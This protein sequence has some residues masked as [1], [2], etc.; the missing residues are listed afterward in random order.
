MP[1]S[2]SGT[3]LRSPDPPRVLRRI[4]TAWGNRGSAKRLGHVSATPRVARG[5]LLTSGMGEATATR[6]RHAED[7]RLPARWLGASV[8][9]PRTYEEIDSDPHALSQAVFVVLAGSVG[10]G[11][12]VFPAEGWLGVLGGTALGVVIWIVATTLVWAIGVHA[13]GH[14]STFPALLRTLGFAAG[15]LVALAACAA[16]PASAARVVSGIVHV[17][18]MLAFAVAVRTA[19]R[20]STLRALWIGAAALGSVLLLLVFAAAVFFDSMLI[21]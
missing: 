13:L 15:P 5:L 19:L 4:A 7:A 17:W 16:L 9:R 3:R 14:A 8:L 11:I 6:A 18:A 12:G 21:D 2:R 20:V 1:T 10:R